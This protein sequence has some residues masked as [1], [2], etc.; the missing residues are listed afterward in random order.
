[1]IFFSFCVLC[2]VL[3][4]SL[5][6]L[7][8]SEPGERRHSKDRK[9]PLSSKGTPYRKKPDETELIQVDVEQSIPC[10]RTPEKISLD[11]GIKC[12][13]AK[14]KGCYAK[15]H[16]GKSVKGNQMVTQMKMCLMESAFSVKRTLQAYISLCSCILQMPQTFWFCLC[17][18]WVAV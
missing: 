11:S 13:T 17:F 7:D 5:D 4:S 9:S 3:S 10:S 8:L 12:Q 15:K 2:P 16:S 1:M 14:V 18:T 6:L